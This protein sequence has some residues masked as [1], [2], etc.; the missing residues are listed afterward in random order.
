M[1]GDTACRDEARLVFAVDQPAFEVGP[2]R[3][4]VLYPLMTMAG[5]RFED[6]DQAFP[7]RGRVWWLLRSTLT[8]DLVVPGSIWTGAIEAARHGEKDRFQ[9]R[10]HDIQPGDPD[11]IEILDVPQADPGLEWV[12]RQRGLKWP[13]P[14]APRVILRGRSSILGPLAASWDPAE[15]RLRLSAPPGDDA[16]VLKVPLEEFR[17]ASRVEEF[18][19]ELGEHTRN[20]SD[21]KPLDLAITKGSWLDMGRLRAAGESLDASTDAQVVTWATRHMP[22]KQ[23]QSIQTAL[24]EL[25]DADPPASNGVGAAR[26]RE[27]LRQIVA[28]RERVLE[29]G[30][31]VARGLAETPAFEEL[32]RKH[33]DT[34]VAARVE[35]ATRR[36]AEEIEGQTK[37]RRDELKRL[38]EK[39]LTLEEEVRARAEAECHALREAEAERVRALDRREAALAEREGSLD[40]RAEAL[41]AGLDRA[42]E[43]YEQHTDQVVS[44]LLNQ[45]P[46]LRR[47]AGVPGGPALAEVP[48]PESA[49]VPAPDLAALLKPRRHTVAPDAAT[50]TE[51]DFLA[52]FDAVVRRRGFTFTT[53]DLINLH[54][55]VKTGGLTILAGPSGTGKSSLPRLYAE[56]LGC[57]DEYLHVPV[58]PDWLDDRDLLGAFNA[59]AGRFE[60]P[61]AG[62][63]ERLIAAAAD[64]AGGYGGIYPICL[65]EMNLARVEHYFAQF[66]SV[67]ELPPD[68][69]ALTLFAP[70]LAR[71]S[72][73]YAAHRRIPLGTNVRF[74]GTVNIDETTH[75]FSPKVLDRAQ[76]VAFAAPDL[77]A[78]G[79]AEPGGAS[80]ASLRPVSLATYLGWARRGPQGGEAREFLLKVNDVLRRSRLGLGYRQRDRVLDYVA[81]ARPFLAEDRA[82]DFQLMQVVLPR[83]RPAA[84]HYKETLRALQEFITRPR[85]PRASDMLGHILEA[86]AENDFFQ[87]L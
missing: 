30:E 74:L 18:R 49:T 41:G 15:Q 48:G 26:K 35:E 31:E 25:R 13:R 2:N 53:E 83:L 60:P 50:V 80:P 29:L 1:D 5:E 62:L 51:A 85:F 75:F 10:L 65:D 56:A 16:E 76:V 34:L 59:I 46:A 17:K 63:V 39:L 72:D 21:R 20:P 23:R 52:Q 42:V 40:A 87:L 79:R 33:I 81:S 32:V 7:Y 55:C 11:L 22:R 45:W 6:V 70:G 43:R 57:L 71:P 84:P 54:A 38:E 68:A 19:V 66:L 27:R 44:D 58:R 77:A 36:R 3:F 28:D 82:L 14:T 4:C 67:L 78:P 37:A 61:S 24:Q 64:E 9:A 8:T 86:P 47:L 12:H 69:R 73:P